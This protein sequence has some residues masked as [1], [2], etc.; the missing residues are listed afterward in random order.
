MRYYLA[1][2]GSLAVVLLAGALGRYRPPLNP[3]AARVVMV[4][5]NN[6]ARI[7]LATGQYLVAESQF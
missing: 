3:Q 1:V 4:N 5:S 7:I 2:A 6:S